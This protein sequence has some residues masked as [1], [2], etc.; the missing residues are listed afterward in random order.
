MLEVTYE[1]LPSDVS[2]LFRYIRNHRS[3]MR[4]IFLY[5]IL[6]IGILMCVASA[7]LILLGFHRNA[8]N[9]SSSLGIGCLLE[10]CSVLYLSYSGII[11]PHIAERQAQRNPQVISRKMMRISPT[12][13]FVRHPLGEVTLHWPLIVDA[14]D[15]RDCYYFFLG[16]ANALAVPKRAFN[17]PDA[18]LAFYSTARQYWQSGKTLATPNQEATPGIWPPAPR[19][20]DSQESGE[21]PNR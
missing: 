1:L 17:S 11:R 18:A 3:K 9:V 19:A 15:G 12:G 13:V 21:T 4:P 5:A 2:Q 10:F 16:R 7:G 6:S 20:R 14:V 8:P